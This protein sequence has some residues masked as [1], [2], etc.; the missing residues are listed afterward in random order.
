[1]KPE[2]K[3]CIGMYLENKFYKLALK[4][5]ASRQKKLY[6]LDVEILQKTV[7]S[8]LLGIEDPR[9]STRLKFIGGS[10]SEKE[11]IR[12]VDKGKASVAFSLFPVDISDLI[13]ITESS[14]LLPPKSTWFEPKLRDGLVIYPLE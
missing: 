1:M 8:P 4:D 6:S 12:A 5:T 7:L 14:G 2:K 9:S 3:G 13:K 10:S 11:L